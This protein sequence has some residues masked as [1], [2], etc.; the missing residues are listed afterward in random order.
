MEI[1][2]LHTFNV[3]STDIPHIFHLQFLKDRRFC[4]NYVIHNQLGHWTA[5]T[6]HTIQLG[7]Q[8]CQIKI[9]FSNDHG[10]NFTGKEGSFKVINVSE[11]FMYNNK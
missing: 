3:L 8:M 2:K 5:I 10:L 6:L 4:T 7:F 9:I 11:E 1:I